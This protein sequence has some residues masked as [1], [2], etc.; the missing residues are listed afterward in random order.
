MSVVKER[1]VLR[2]CRREGGKTPCRIRLD[3]L[4]KSDSL[5]VEIVIDKQS[6]RVY[7]CLF[8]P[9][10]LAGRRGVTFRENGDEIY[11]LSGLK[12]E[13][14]SRQQA[15]AL[16]AQPDD[17]PKKTERLSGSKAARVR[18]SVLVFGM[19]GSLV[20]VHR[21]LEDVAA[22]MNLRAEAIDK[23]CRTKRHSMETGYSFRYKKKAI[24]SDVTDFTLTL[25]RYDELCKRRPKDRDRVAGGLKREKA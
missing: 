17:V 10:S 14:L 21:T 5:L 11:W 13:L 6:D 23:L 9:E 25:S 16:L 22:A 3:A 18:H 20:A 24:D 15:E 19:Q 2:R 12:P 1:V 4:Q 7:H 8:S